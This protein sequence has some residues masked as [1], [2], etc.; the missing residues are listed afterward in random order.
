ML[1][2][3][4]LAVMIRPSIRR[5][6]CPADDLPANKHQLGRIQQSKGGTPFHYRTMRLCYM[7]RGRCNGC[8]G[9][10]D[11]VPSLRTACLRSELLVIF[12]VTNRKQEDRLR[13]TIEIYMAVYTVNM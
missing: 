8:R 11:S 2:S 1:H 13:L 6:F 3:P 12:E 7:S 4:K 10:G 9:E 5:S